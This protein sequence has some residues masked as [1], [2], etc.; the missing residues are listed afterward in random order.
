MRVKMVS[1]KSDDENQWPV[2][3]AYNRLA[4]RGIVEPLKCHICGHEVAMKQRG[5]EPVFLCW[6]CE[7][8]IVPGLN[9]YESIK[10]VVENTKE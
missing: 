7:Q 9:T 4:R 6:N 2:Y 10:W 8:I 5:G 3:H 1:Q